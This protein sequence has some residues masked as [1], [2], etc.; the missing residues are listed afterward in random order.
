MNT[1]EE[2]IM[3]TNRIYMNNMQRNID[4]AKTDEERR[5]MQEKRDKRLAL[6]NENRTDNM[7]EF[8]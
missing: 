2:V 4:N 6:I 7:P 3:R 1:L 5:L 8:I